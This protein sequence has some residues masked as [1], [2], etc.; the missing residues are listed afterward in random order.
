MAVSETL[1]YTLN[2]LQFFWFGL[3]NQIEQN[4]PSTSWTKSKWKALSAPCCMIEYNLLFLT[5]TE[6]TAGSEETRIFY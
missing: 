4:P 6:K 2:A 3:Q 5:R 1:H